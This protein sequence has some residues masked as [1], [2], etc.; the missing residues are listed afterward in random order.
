MMRIGIPFAKLSQKE[1]ALKIN[2]DP[3]RTMSD[4]PRLAVHSG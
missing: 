1:F 2:S 3:L 4:L